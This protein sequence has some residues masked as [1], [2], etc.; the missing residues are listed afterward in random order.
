MFFYD[1]RLN[2]NQLMIILHVE[3][4]AKIRSRT[5][6]NIKKIQGSINYTHILIRCDIK[7]IKM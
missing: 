1:V 4:N 3:S 5:V 6:I 7:G 2:E